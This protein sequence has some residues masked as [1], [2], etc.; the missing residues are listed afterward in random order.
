MYLNIAC[1]YVTETAWIL[2]SVFIG[3]LW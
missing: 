3:Q 1:L 2:L